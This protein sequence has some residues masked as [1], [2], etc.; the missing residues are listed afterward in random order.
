MIAK[1][2]VIA[3]LSLAAAAVLAATVAP[4]TARASTATPSPSISPATTKVVVPLTNIYGYKCPSGNLCLWVYDPNATNG[5]GAYDVF[6]L[7]ACHTY[8]VSYWH[9]SA[10]YEDNQ[11]GGVTSYFYGQSGNTLTH[12]TPTGDTIKT[13]SGDWDPVWSVK[14]C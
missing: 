1:Y 4:G 14:N 5:R 12:F 2:R 8:S 11:T 13:Y 9:G 3:T 6:D 10:T 7:D